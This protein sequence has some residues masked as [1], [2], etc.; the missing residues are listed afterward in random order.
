M[1]ISAGEVLAGV[2]IAGRIQW[3]IIMAVIRH[4]PA[5]V[6]NKLNI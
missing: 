1:Q 2:A 4:L 5:M 6:F 3:R